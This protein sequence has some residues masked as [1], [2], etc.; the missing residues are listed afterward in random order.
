MGL[1]AATLKEQFWYQRSRIPGY[2]RKKQRVALNS[3]KRPP[4]S[5]GGFLFIGHEMMRRGK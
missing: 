5:R 1:T 2:L 3:G 4:V